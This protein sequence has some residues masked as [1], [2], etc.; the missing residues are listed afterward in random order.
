MPNA[1]GSR[2]ASATHE[3]KLGAKAE[4][5][6]AHGAVPAFAGRSRSPCGSSPAACCPLDVW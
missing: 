6:G 5:R 3:R 1:A 4:P 2:P